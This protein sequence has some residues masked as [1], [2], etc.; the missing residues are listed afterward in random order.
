[1]HRSRLAQLVIDCETTDPDWAAQFW[2]RAL[3]Y[4]VLPPD[5]A[6]DA[7]YRRLVNHFDQPG[8]LIQGVTHASRMHLDIETNDVESEVVR[9]EHLGAVRI[10]QVKQWWVMGA[11]TGQ[12]FCV[13]PP[14]RGDFPAHS[15][16]WR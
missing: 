3:G 7:M 11:P 4:R 5:N 8:I 14:Q 12:R 1:M 6:A 16:V 13:L 10:S 9:L 2:G 15:N